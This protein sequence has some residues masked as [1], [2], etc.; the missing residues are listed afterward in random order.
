MNKSSKANTDETRFR[1]FQCL[2][3][4]ITCYPGTR[5]LFIDHEKFKECK[6]QD[7][8]LEIWGSDETNGQE[9]T[10]F[11]KFAAFAMMGNEISNAVE[12][13]PPSRLAHL[14]DTGMD[15][16]LFDSLIS[17]CYK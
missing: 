10:L 15:W 14:G 17:C 6:S 4:L 7:N 16:T 11:L 9:W 3:M 2:I 12:K 8:V 5:Q 1:T 13:L